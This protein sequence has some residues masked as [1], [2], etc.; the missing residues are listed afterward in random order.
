MN[1]HTPGPWKYGAE[2]SS[3]TGEW[4]IS[5]DAGNRGRGIGIAETR[6]GSGQEEANARLI[7]AAP[8]LL[9]AC[10]T[11]HEWL[12]REEIGFANKWDRNTEEGEAKWREWYGENLRLCAL[13]QEQARAAIAKAKGETK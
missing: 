10:E 9:E 3:R 7:A 4:L 12:V 6:P 13:A 11:F 2:L 5:F 8:D 1:K